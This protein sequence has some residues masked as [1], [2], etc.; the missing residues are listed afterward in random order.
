MCLGKILILADLALIKINKI[1]K[2]QIQNRFLE[3]DC[4]CVLK[5]TCTYMPINALLL[6]KRV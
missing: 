2:R 5:D 3:T 4:N 1:K 6:E